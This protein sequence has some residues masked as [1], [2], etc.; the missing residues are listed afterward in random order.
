MMT[1]TQMPASTIDH[2]ANCLRPRQLSSTHFATL[3]RG[4]GEPV[5]L[6]NLIDHGDCADFTSQFLLN[7]SAR[8]CRA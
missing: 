6:F 3:G 7:N 2:A 5:A 4:T 8:H 1:H